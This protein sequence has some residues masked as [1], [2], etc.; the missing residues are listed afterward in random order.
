[1]NGNHGSGELLQVDGE[2]GLN[3]APANSQLLPLEDTAHDAERVVETALHFVQHL[4]V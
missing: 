4:V 2:G 3:G 1:M